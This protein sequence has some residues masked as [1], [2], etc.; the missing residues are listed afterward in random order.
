[1]CEMPEV[2]R[3]SVQASRKPRRCCECGWPIESG[4][5]YHRTWGVWDGEPMTFVTCLRC[6]A[7][8]DEHLANLAADYERTK[9]S[10]PRERPDLCWTYGDL[11]EE[12]TSCESMDHGPEVTLLIARVQYRSERKRAEEYD[13]LVSDGAGQVEAFAKPIPMK[14]AQ[15]LWRVGHAP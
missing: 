13:R 14:G 5:R 3:E 4:E 12:V 2:M 15:G 9:A 7:A 8:R 6:I 1:M 10:Y 11:Y